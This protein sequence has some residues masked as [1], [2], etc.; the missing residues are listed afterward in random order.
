M[1]HLALKKKALSPYPLSGSHCKCFALLNGQSYMFS[2]WFISSTSSVMKYVVTPTRLLDKLHPQWHTNPQAITDHIHRGEQSSAGKN[3]LHQGIP[4]KHWGV[5]NWAEAV[6]TL[7]PFSSVFLLLGHPSW[8]GEAAI[9][10]IV[11]DSHWAHLQYEVPKLQAHWLT[12]ASHRHY[13]SEAGL[14]TLQ[15]RK[16]R[17]LSNLLQ[18][19][20]TCAK[21]ILFTVWFGAKFLPQNATLPHTHA[22]TCTTLRERM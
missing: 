9:A 7:L 2:P 16:P 19:Q 1:A 13:V 20:V 5:Q 22:L 15:K 14:F 6:A 21:V 12:D 11:L 18:S 10:L 4:V 8:M 3:N 17:R